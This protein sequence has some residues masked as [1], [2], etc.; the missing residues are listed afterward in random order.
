MWEPSGQ[1]EWL[2]INWDLDKGII[3]IPNRKLEDIKQSFS[4]FLSLL[5]NFSPRDVARLTGKVISLMPVFGDICRLLTRHMYLQ[6]QGYAHW[7]KV[8]TSYDNPEFV[9]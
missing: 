8:V 4:K 5:P 9:L 1:L 3:S 7:D 2:G 6:I